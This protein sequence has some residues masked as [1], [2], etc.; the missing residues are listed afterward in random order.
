MANAVEEKTL[1]DDDIRYEKERWF[2]HTA[3]VVFG[4]FFVFVGVPIWWRTT[5][6]YR[7]DLPYS[8]IQQAFNAIPNLRIDLE[9][10]IG[11]EEVDPIA[12]ARFG[13][14]LQETFARMNNVKGFVSVKYQGTVRLALQQELQQLNALT[15]E[16]LDSFPGDSGEKYVFY[17]VR[18]LKAKV[19]LPYINNRRQIFLALPS[20]KSDYVIP[21]AEAVCEELF[22]PA[23]LSRSFQVV[24]GEPINDKELLRSLKFDPTYTVVFS[25]LVSQPD[26]VLASWDMSTAVPEYLYDLQTALSDYV[27]IKVKS[28]VLYYEVLPIQPKKEENKGYY[29]MTPKDMPHLIN[30]VEARL[31]SFVDTNPALNFIVYVPTREQYPLHLHDEQGKKVLANSFLV[32]RWGGFYIY[33]VNTT[34]DSYPVVHQVDME[35]VFSELIPQLRSLL[36]IAP[37]S[38]SKILQQPTVRTDSF[39]H[40]E[41]DQWLRQRTVENIGTTTHALYSLSNLVQNIRNMII[42][43]NIS[44]QVKD[45]VA[46]VQQSHRLLTRGAIHEAFLAS[47]EALISAEKAFFDPSL[48]ELL[49]FPEDQKFAIYIPLFLP[50]G[51]PLFTSTLAAIKWFR[52]KRTDQQKEKED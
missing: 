31:G 34:A 9:F 44:E 27:D 35:Q 45:S 18:R 4:L 38:E 36:G 11:S 32:P 8:E 42:N 40:W 13:E 41:I 17:L 47:K 39:S 29:Y 7:A 22:R 2:S 3:S 49:Y 6:V 16:E 20:G 21:Q 10:V 51:I 52:G 48:L 30:P 46:A 43:D 37:I 5:T 12:A 19:T 15:S 14:V 25:L 23:A 1:C 26:Q 33:N 24:H 50:I 28:Q